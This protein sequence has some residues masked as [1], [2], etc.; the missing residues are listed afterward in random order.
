LEVW[1]FFEFR[2]LIFE[3]IFP[4]KI[5]L[6]SH[7]KPHPTSLAENKRIRKEPPENSAS[8]NHPFWQKLALNYRL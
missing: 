6:P 4:K 1:I 5:I 7:L 8:E 3:F 2:V